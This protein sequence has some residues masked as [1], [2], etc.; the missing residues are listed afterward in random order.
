MVEFFR[1]LCCRNRAFT[2]D[3]YGDTMFRYVV[4]RLW[5]S[6][7]PGSLGEIATKIGELG[8]DLVGIDILER[9]GARAVDELTVELPDGYRPEA[10]ADALSQLSG[11][12]VEDLRHRVSQVPYAGRD[13]LD[14][15]VLLVESIG[16][17]NS[18]TCSLKASAPP[19]PATGARCS[20]RET[21]GP[22]WW[23]RQAIGRVPPGWARLQPEHEQACRFPPAAAQ[24]WS[25]LGTSPGRHSTCRV[26]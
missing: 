15:A 13:P 26:S 16:P 19:S 21:P 5:L 22:S 4:V 6:D 2:S 7:R 10:L 23:Q 11:V 3:A 12:E 17:T 8:G 20:T 9:D 25:V 14:T 18:R 24:G 1:C